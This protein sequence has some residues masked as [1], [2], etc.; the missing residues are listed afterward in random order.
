MERHVEESCDVNLHATPLTVTKMM[1]TPIISRETVRWSRPEGPIAPNAV[2]T[3]T[4]H[5]ATK[6]MSA[7][8]HRREPGRHASRPQQLFGGSSAK[9]LLRNPF[10]G[11]GNLNPVGDGTGTGIAPGACT[12]G[13]CPG[14]TCGWNGTIAF[15]TNPFGTKLLGTKLCTIVPG[16]TKM[17]AGCEGGG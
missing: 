15:G 8:N 13:T 14:T 12:K 9:R 5:T 2:P 17:L 16:G 6:A 11:S 10:A 4:Q 3:N 1:P 7:M